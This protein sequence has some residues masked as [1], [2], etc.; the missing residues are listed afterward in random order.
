MRNGLEALAAEAADRCT[1]CGKC[2][3][4]C[5]TAREI[6]L[7]AGEAVQ[8][9]GELMALTAAARRRPTACRNGWAPATAARAAAPPA[10]RTSTSANG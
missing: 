8:R 7:D 5:P 9:V 10:P 2:F 6:G 4:V 1:T 3:E